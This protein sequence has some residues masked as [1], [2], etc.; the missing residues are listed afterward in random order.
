MTSH[1]DQDLFPESAATKETSCSRKRALGFAI[2]QD[3]LVTSTRT[4]SPGASARDRRTT[5]GAG[6]RA[7]AARSQVPAGL[8]RFVRRG[9]NSPRASIAEDLSMPF[10]SFFA[11]VVLAV[12]GAW[13]G[14]R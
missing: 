4:I 1:P 6:A 3:S 8:R 10:G 13:R 5:S 11:A 9:K 2:S 7:A 14:G 12:F